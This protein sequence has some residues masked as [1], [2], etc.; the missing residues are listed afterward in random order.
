[1]SI[2]SRDM[3]KIHLPRWEEFPAFDLYIDQ[4]I[5]FVSEYLSGFNHSDEP[6]LTASM[7]NNYVK[8]GVLHA[9]VKKKYNREHLA[10][11]MVICICKRML[12]LSYISESISLMS[13]VYEIS[14]GYDIF[15]D[16]VEYE[17]KSTVSPESYPPHTISEAETKRLQTMR[18]LASSVARILVFDRLLEQRRRISE[19]VGK[20]INK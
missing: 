12:P 2:G 3:T 13:R 9:P 15:C 19:A 20:M 5:A 7:I 11:L 4:V 8:N 17:I 10:K 14:E 6:F 16:E 1:M 18:L